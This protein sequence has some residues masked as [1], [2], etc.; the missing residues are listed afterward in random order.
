M[1]VAWE[2]LAVAGWAVLLLNLLLT[3]RLVRWLRSYQDAGRLDSFRADLPELRIGE[4]APDFRARDLSGRIVTSGDFPGRDLALVFVSP[5]CGLCRRELPGLAPLAGVAMAAGTEI[6]LV[7][8]GGAGETES[9][10][11]EI[12]AENNVDLRSWRV[13]LAPARTSDFQIRYNP[14][15]LTPY[16]CHID[17]AGM[18]TARGGLHTPAWAAVVRT[19]DPSAGAHRNSRR[20]R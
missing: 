19:W 14:R 13:L 20:Y 1:N 4:L 8:G 3:M 15:A 11:D 9:W 12:S 6:V 7:S 2:A 5:E 17:R 16:F 18:V 10:L